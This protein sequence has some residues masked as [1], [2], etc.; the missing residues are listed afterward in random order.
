MGD[1]RTQ[2]GVQV[3]RS[4]FLIV[5]L[6]IVACTGPEPSGSP[7]SSLLNGASPTS[8]ASTTPSI[9]PATAEPSVELEPTPG[10]TSDNTYPLRTEVQ[11]NRDIVV[12]SG[13]PVDMAG[14]YWWTEFGDAGEVGTTA[15]IGL[16]AGEEILT[17][18]DGL[19]VS[20]RR[21]GPGYF[22]RVDLRI[23][24]LRTGELL[25][26]IETNVG[27]PRAVL[28]GRRLFWHG[29]DPRTRTD[30][31]Y[32]DG[33]VW[34]ATINGNDAPR[35]IIH[36]GAD[37]AYLTYGGRSILEVS[38]SGRTLASDVG[39]FSGTFIDFIDTE[40]LTVRGRIEDKA[41]YALT[42]DAF[43]TS[44]GAPSDTPDGRGLSAY[45]IRTG[46]RL[47]RFPGG[48]DADR[49]S[50]ANIRA[51][52]NGFVFQYIWRGPPDTE[53]RF[54]SVG[55]RSGRTQWQFVES[56]TDEVRHRYA[57][58]PASTARH[59]A[60]IDDLGSIGSMLR[61]GPA[62]VSIYDTETDTFTEDAFVI[63]PP[64]L[65]FANRCRD[66]EG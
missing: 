18:G 9:G 37:L 64:W 10:P 54:E 61:D 45:D 12:R 31:V 1:S 27:A 24:E 62:A 39:G 6:A 4:Q 26:K 58:F 2:A 33:G 56:E 21:E 32:I 35:A 55:F 17:V 46:E 50:I 44:D 5:T 42:D 23:R 7:V 19:V 41:A 25:R 47:W 28:V 20:A 40:T 53:Y 57:T 15:Q 52:G 8:P 16:P 22:G 65:C 30:E 63:D 11:I 38:P 29:M 43:V 49:F 59:I 34:T 3:R 36:G 66:F 48:D 14:L 51:L 60:V 13:V